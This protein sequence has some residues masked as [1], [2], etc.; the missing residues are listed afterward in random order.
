MNI[1]GKSITILLVSSI[2]V[3][4]LILEH[5]I[6][7]YQGMS[8]DETTIVDTSYLRPSC[9]CLKLLFCV[10]YYESTHWFTF[11][12]RLVST[13]QLE[14]FDMLCLTVFNQ[15][16]LLNIFHFRELYCVTAGFAASE[17]TFFLPLFHRI[18]SLEPDI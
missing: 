12:R 11:G 5:T 3:L 14:K 16:N 7:R 6:S 17:M 1:S 15:T 8:I 2:K 9:S 10:Y 4:I 13:R 18:I